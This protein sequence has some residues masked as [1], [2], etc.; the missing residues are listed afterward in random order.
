MKGQHAVEWLMAEAWE[1]CR[2]RCKRR[3]R[4]S[5]DRLE[6]DERGSK[7]MEYLMLVVENVWKAVVGKFIQMLV[8][9]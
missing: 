1:Y 4:A 5:K 3:R 2:S 8:D 6:V 9:V 7:W